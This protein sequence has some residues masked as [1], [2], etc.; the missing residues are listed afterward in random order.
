MSHQFITLDLND[1]KLVQS[2]VEE[3]K[4]KVVKPTEEEVLACV[5]IY[6]QELPRTLRR[7]FQDFTT[8]EIADAISVKTGDFFHT[9]DIDT[10]SDYPELNS[11]YVYNDTQIAHALMATLIGTPV[12]YSSQRSGRRL[13]N[14]IPTQGLEA[15]PNSSSGSKHDFGF[16]TEDAFHE[17][18]G[19]YLGLACIRNDESAVTSFV[20][21]NEIQLKPALKAALF[22]NEY[23]IGHNPIHELT[24]DFMPTKQSILYGAWD[25]PY[26]R[27]NVNNTRGVDKSSRYALEEFVDAMNAARE[28]AVLEA[29][30]FF[31]LDNLYT[32]HARDAYS[33]NWGD[34]ARWLSRFI[35]T[36]DIRKSTVARKDWRSFIIENDYDKNAV[37]AG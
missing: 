9:V 14:I 18:K 16:H 32:A 21:I 2:L 29:G 4:S 19:D 26:M 37:L 34:R 33:P 5:P 6:A 17:F 10:P 13:N 11:D 12:G 15:I 7:F 28:R 3:I 24:T 20:S 35:I 22:K 36:K 8:H 27:I 30:D 1:L 31:Y 25:R 23:V